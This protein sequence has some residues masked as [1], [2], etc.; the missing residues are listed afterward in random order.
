MTPA[1]QQKLARADALSFLKGQRTGVLATEFESNPFASTVYYV[2]DDDFTIY[3]ATRRNTAKY[4]NLAANSRVAFVV[5]A[6]PEHVSV[7]IRGRAE[8]LAGQ[9][10]AR[11]RGALRRQKS[12]HDVIAFPLKNMDDFARGDDVIFKIVPSA[13]QFFNLD[14]RS[15]PNS[16]SR[17]YYM[18]T[19][20]NK[21]A[22]TL[23][24]APSVS[25]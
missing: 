1:L 6:G 24:T 12:R 17:R 9:E 8:T 21:E 7:Q 15:L 18:L 14:N 11:V 4:A 10:R 2:T 16:L 23:E 5:G 20:Q 25:R 19:P 22:V 3:F 13:I